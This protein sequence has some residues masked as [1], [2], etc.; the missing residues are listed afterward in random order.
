MQPLKIL[1]RRT[2]KP[3]EQTQFELVQVHEK[4]LFL[5]LRNTPDSRYMCT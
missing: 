4:F 5:L 2:E 3:L 1:E